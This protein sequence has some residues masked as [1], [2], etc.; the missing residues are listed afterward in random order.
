VRLARVMLQY[1]IQAMARVLGVIFISHSPHKPYPVGYRF[2]L[3]NRG[4][5]IGFYAKEQVT[6]EELTGLMAGGSEL[7]QLS[8]ELESA[9]GAAAEAA[10]ELEDDASELGI[11]RQPPTPGG[12]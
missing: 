3:L 12:S 1:S 7:A 2:L 5:G 10:Q 9:G 8:H 6:L 11:S 4:K